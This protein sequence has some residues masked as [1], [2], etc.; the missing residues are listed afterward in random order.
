MDYLIIASSSPE[1]HL[2]NL[3]SV[4]QHLNE[5]EIG[6]NV[7]NFGVSELDFLCHHVGATCIL[8]LEDRV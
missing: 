7:S 2:E 8:P 3:Q 6:I 5:H 4:F 1:E